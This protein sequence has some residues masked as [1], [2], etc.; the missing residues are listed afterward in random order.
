M[1]RK[2]RHCGGEV[3]SSRHGSSQY[4]IKEHYYEAKKQRSKDRYKAIKALHDEEKRNENLLAFFY[5]ILSMKKQISLQDMVDHKFN[6][7]LTTGETQY[8]GRIFKV[9]GSY[10]YYIQPQTKSIEIWK[11]TSKK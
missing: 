5:S 9:V 2:C 7:G 10:A 3:S 4:C 6:L 11:L 8:N 1:K